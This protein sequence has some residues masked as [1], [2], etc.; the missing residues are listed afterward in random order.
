MTAGTRRAPAARLAVRVIPRAG[1]DAIEGVRDAALIVRVSAAPVDG[2]ANAAV[3]RLV[4]EA[5]GIPAS[6][7]SV[8]SGASGRRKV[9]SLEGLDRSAIVARWPDLGV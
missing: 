3:S 7:V 8:I 4:G 9:L 2:A 1:R 6:R 5:L